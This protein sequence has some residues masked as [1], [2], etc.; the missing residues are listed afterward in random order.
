MKNDDAFEFEE[1]DSESMPSGSSASVRCTVSRTRPSTRKW[2]H[3]STRAT[4]AALH[5]IRWIPSYHQQPAVWPEGLFLGRSG[6]AVMEVEPTPQEAP[7]ASDEKQSAATSKPQ[8]QRKWQ[9]SWKRTWPWVVHHI[10]SDGTEAMYC[11]ICFSQRESL[12]REG[13]RFTLQWIEG[14]PLMRSDLLRQHAESWMHDAAI[15]L[16]KLAKQQNAEDGEKEIREKNADTCISI[17]MRF[18]RRELFSKR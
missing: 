6:G 15:Q 9:E 8:P 14:C 5:P 12:P 11:A 2:D 3:S 1:I 13:I 7:Q 17:R 4:P 16:A 18:V 10:K